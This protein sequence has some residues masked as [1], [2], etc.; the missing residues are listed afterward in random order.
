MN[1]MAREQ[2]GLEMNPGPFG[3]NSRPALIG[4]KYAEAQGKG[5]EY[6]TAVMDAYWRDAK[7]IDDL[8]VLGDLVA[9]IGLDQAA[10]LAALTDSA[11]IEQVDD[12]IALAQEYG[13]NGVP[14]LV[15][16]NKYLVS[17]AQPY[18]VLQQVIAQ[19]QGEAA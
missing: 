19:I 1:A 10:F 15:F 5:G 8:A 18:P 6:H 13:I 11:L 17:G 7:T 4:Y 12:D 3:M 16:A 9:G 14:A 2:Y